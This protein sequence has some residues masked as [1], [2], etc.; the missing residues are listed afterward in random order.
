MV[1]LKINLDS[2]FTMASSQIDGETCC[3]PTISKFSPELLKLFNYDEDAILEY[4]QR[5][6]TVIG[7]DITDYIVGDIVWAKIWTYPFWPAIVCIDPI[8]KK[9]IKG[10]PYY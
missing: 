1:C 10:W 5:K 7:Q 3:K 9:F 8:D 2:C 4:Q 6:R